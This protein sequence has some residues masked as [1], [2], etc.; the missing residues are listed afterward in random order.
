LT[1]EQGADTLVFLASS[2]DVATVT[3]QY[4]T[5]GHSLEPSRAAR[6]DAAAQRLWVE[7][8]KLA[9]RGG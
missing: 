6:D 4:F 9:A 8:E 1:P 2:P 3:G 5:K 7:S